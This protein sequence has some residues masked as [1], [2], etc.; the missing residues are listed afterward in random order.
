MFAAGNTIIKTAG[1][2]KSSLKIK[3]LKKGTYYVK[4]RTIRTAGGVKYTGK[5]SK[6]QKVKIK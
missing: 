3:K 6:P 4:V 5:W 1:K 2:S